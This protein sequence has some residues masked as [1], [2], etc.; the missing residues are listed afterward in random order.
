MFQ[1]DVPIK[2]WGD[3]IAT[4]TII[5]N[6]T[7]SVVSKSKSPYELLYDKLPVYSELKVFGCLCYI[8]TIPQ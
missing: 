5:I 2:L 8:S 4:T 6:R 1:P 7:P 3:C